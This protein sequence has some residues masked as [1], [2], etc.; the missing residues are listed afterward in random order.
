MINAGKNIVGHKND[1][2]PVHK[3]AMIRDMRVGALLLGFSSVAFF[4]IACNDD[5]E[6]ETAPQN[7]PPVISRP[8]PQPEREA[9]A[10]RANSATAPESLPIGPRFELYSMYAGQDIKQVTGVSG[11]TLWLCFT[12]PWCSHSK[13][14][15]R[16]LK[17]MAHEEKGN[18]QVVELNA[19][20][21]PAIAEQFG[22]TKVPTTILY[23]EGIKLRT[24][25]GAY[26][27]TSL[28]RYLHKVLSRDEETPPSQSSASPDL[29]PSTSH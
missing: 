23:T 4:L 1:F 13:D 21:Y 26:N 6:G 10:V 7:V 9:L 3:Y 19:D 24:I 20:E 8:A 12:A 28:R 29:N 16:E 15:I 17:L 5:E 27:A 22:I 2:T 14:M 25:E 18:V 11:R